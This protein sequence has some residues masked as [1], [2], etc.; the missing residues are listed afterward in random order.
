MITIY[1]AITNEY[2]V[3]WFPVGA[4][5]L[6]KTWSLHPMMGWPIE[7]YGN[8]R[9]HRS[10]CL[11][12]TKGVCGSFMSIHILVGLPPDAH[13]SRHGQWC[14]RQLWKIINHIFIYVM[15]GLMPVMKRWLK[16]WKGDMDGILT[17]VCA[18]FSRLSF[19]VII[20][21]QHD[22]WVCSPLSLLQ[23]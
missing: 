23:F 11:A 13:H 17:F 15:R 19:Q 12:W 10:M 7:W 3:L 21:P 18:S 5:I 20:W 6:S 16:G 14:Y 8:I 22:R 1:I 4:N 2:I 9:G